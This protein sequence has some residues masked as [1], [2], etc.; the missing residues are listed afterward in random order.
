MENNH[1][2]PGRLWAEV[3]NLRVDRPHERCME[4]H[5]RPGAFQYVNLF[6][7]SGHWARIWLAEGSGHEKMVDPKAKKAEKKDL[8][9]ARLVRT[10]I[11]L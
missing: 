11:V 9:T 1:L 7:E 5:L 4:C 10:K 8:V 6:V 2:E 3:V